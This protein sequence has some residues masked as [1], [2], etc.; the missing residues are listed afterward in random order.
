[1]TWDPDNP[2]AWRVADA[3]GFAVHWW[4]NRLSGRF[5]DDWLDEGRVDVQ[6]AAMIIV[7]AHR[8][9][10]TVDVFD[11]PEAPEALRALAEAISTDRT[12]RKA[13]KSE[14]VRVAY[15]GKS[16]LLTGEWEGVITAC[17]HLLKTQPNRYAGEYKQR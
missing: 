7:Y 16:T 15:G 5:E 10:L 8:Q 14:M 6:L 9:G 1:M 4:Q 17:E 2:A 3:I 12:L 11:T 13:L